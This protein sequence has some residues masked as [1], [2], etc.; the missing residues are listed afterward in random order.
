M[1]R[2]YITIAWRNILN[3]KVYSAINILG[4]AAGMAV[5]LMIGLWVV[6][7]YSYD[8]FLSN[9]EQLYQVEQ[10]FSTQHD[11]EHTQTAVSLPLA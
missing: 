11:G 2:N 4:L 9:Y 8:R 7:E 6:N 1:L 5:A 3:N 10:H